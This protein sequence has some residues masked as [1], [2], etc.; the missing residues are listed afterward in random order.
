MDA[1]ND[2]VNKA[3]DWIWVALVGAFIT[4]AGAIIRIWR[5]EER[6]KALEAASNHKL[7]IFNGLAD[8]VDM[9]HEAIT[10]RLDAA[11]KEIREDLRI[12]MTRC[13]MVRHKDDQ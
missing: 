8:K 12:I 11:V 6:L 4:V 2:F 7:T 1:G 10:D 3:L 5:H 9:N 13:L